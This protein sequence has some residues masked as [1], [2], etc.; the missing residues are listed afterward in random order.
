MRCAVL[1]AFGG[2]VEMASRPAPEPGPGEVLVEVAGCGVGL[3]LER[4]RAG[5]LGG[6]TPRIVGHEI[7]GRIAARGPGVEGWADGDAVT[8]SFYLTCGGCAMCASGRETLCSRFGGYIGCHI[9]GGLAEF[10]VLPARNLVRIPDGLPVAEAGIVADA[11]ATPY[12]VATARARITPGQ[13]VAVIGAG[14]GVGIHMVETAKAFGGQVVAVERDPDK[15]ARLKEGGAEAVF[16]PGADDAWADRFRSEL[17]A[18]DVC[19]DTVASASTLAQGVRICGPSGTFVLVGY[20]PGQ[21]WDLDPVHLLLNEA[22][23]VGSRYATRADIERALDLVASGRVR[24]AIGA[25]FDLE[26]TPEAYR[27]MQRNEVFGRIL[28][29]RR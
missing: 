3:T 13:T 8:T 27:A 17:G 2:P 28:V 21:R 11:I 7:G 24:T 6:S 18:V 12:H 20:Q 1:E 15:L 4:A 14:G 25:R 9:D 5:G 26:E 16:D 22:Q 29:E 23:V 19:V 10:V